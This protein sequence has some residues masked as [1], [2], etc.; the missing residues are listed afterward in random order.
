MPN[1]SDI[2]NQ[3]LRDLICQ[4]LNFDPEKR[5]T[6]KEIINTI[7]EIEN[8]ESEYDIRRL[9]KFKSINN[10]SIDNKTKH[11]LVEDETLNSI[12]SKSQ[13]KSITHLKDDQFFKRGKADFQT[14]IQKVKE[15]YNK[16][17]KKIKNFSQ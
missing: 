1:I 8:D 7:E 6:A 4:C 10:E 14:I 17:A 12:E 16:I 9:S 15:N 13:T 11:E 5:P 2:K 3:I